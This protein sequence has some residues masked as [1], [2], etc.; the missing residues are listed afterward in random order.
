MGLFLSKLS[1]KR[2]TEVK[3]ADS[4][5]G[6]HVTIQIVESYPQQEIWYP[7]KYHKEQH[8]FPEKK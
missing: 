6:E 3:A 2:T 5:Q 1:S 7:S 8:Q 4:K